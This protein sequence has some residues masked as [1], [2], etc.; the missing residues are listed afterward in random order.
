MIALAKAS[1]N[2]GAFTVTLTT[3]KALVLSTPIKLTVKASGLLDSAGEPL[4][5]GMNFSAVVAKSGVK[6]TSASR[7]AQR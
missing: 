7:L 4:D 3:R 2:P 1:Y 5:S 6:V